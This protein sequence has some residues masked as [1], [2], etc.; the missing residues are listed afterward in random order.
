MVFT[1]LKVLY[2]FSLIADTTT[3]KTF[4]ANATTESSE[5]FNRKDESSARIV[6]Y[7]SEHDGVGNY[8]FK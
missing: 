5:L 1:V 6:S 3:D 2:I 7:S 8:H 4:E